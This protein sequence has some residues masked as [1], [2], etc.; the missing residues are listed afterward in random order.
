MKK[1]GII[2]L[3]A[4]VLSTTIVSA[5]GKYFTKNGKITFFSSTSFEDIEAVNRSVSVVLDSKTGD[6]QFAVLIKGFQFKK[7]LMQE[8]FN[9]RHMESDKYPQSEFKGKITN[10]N[11]INYTKDGS[12]TA[13]VKGVLTI[14]GITKEIET[15]GTIKVANGKIDSHSIFNIELAD[16]K[17]SH[18]NKVSNSIKITVDCSLEPFG[19]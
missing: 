9:E 3:T 2:L 7:A 15:N 6:L 4:F 13:R 14:H 10:N 11:A 5:Q 12:Y 1:I 19:Q 18:T 17:V 16:Y 8:H